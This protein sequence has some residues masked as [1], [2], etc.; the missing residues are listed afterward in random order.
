MPT[1]GG[2]IRGM[3]EKFNANPVTGTGSMTVP[4]ATSPGRSGFGPQLSLTYDSGRGNGPFGL[5]WSLSAPAIT[6]KTDKGLPR[7]DDANESDV[8]LLSDAEDLVPARDPTDGWARHRL[9]DPPHAP[10]YRIDR[11]RPRIERSFARVERWTRLSDG[12]AHWRVTTAE[13]VTTWYGEDEDSRIFDPDVPNDVPERV[14]SWLISRTYDDKGNVVVYRYVADD[15][16]GVDVSAAHERNRTD[17]VRGTNRY[18]KR[19]L[20][21]NRT[22]RLVEPDLDDPRWMF[23]VVLD[24]GD[25]DPESP[26]P[27]HDRDWPCREDPFSSYRSGFEVR[28]YRRCQRVLMFHHFPDEAGVGADCLVRSTVFEYTPGDAVGALLTQVHQRGHRR[29]DDGYVTRSLPPLELTYSSSAQHDE[30]REVD[31]ISLEGVPAGVGDGYQWVDLDGE[32]LSGILATDP[33]GW[34]YKRNVGGGRFA[35]PRLVTPLPSTAADSGTQPQ[36]LDLAG[37][38]QLDLVLLGAPTPG[39]FERTRTG[40]VEPPGWETFTAFRSR[41][42][43]DFD[44]PN[45]RFVDLDGD[46]HADVLITEDGA[47]RWYESL[48]EGGFDAARI[49]SVPVDEERGPRILFADATRSVHLADMSGDGLTDLVRIRNGEVCYWPN[50]GHG[51]FGPKVTMDGAPWFD[52]DETYD[53]RYLRLADV[54]G[55]GV[56]DL[57]YL[58]ADATRIWRN[59]SGNAW[60]EAQVLASAPVADARAQVAAVDLLGTGTTCLVWS[61]D[62]PTDARRNLRYIDLLGST[63]PHLLVRVANNLG[64]ETHVR[65]APSTRFYLEDRAA[66]RPWVTRLPFPVHVVERVET[67]DL[68]SRNRFVSRYAYH[69]GYFDGEERE[70][71]GFGM[72][73][74]WDT[75]AFTA[76]GGD[77]DFANEDP[78]SHVPPVHTKTWFHTGAFGAAGTSVSRYF[79]DEYW[80]EPGLT[81]DQQRA[82]LL[83]DT[84]WPTALLEPDGTRIDHVPTAEEIREACRALKGSM[85]RQEVYADDGSEAEERPHV[86]T[87]RNYRLDLLQPELDGDRHAVC[88]TSSLEAVTYQYE[89]TLYD[90]EHPDGS[91]ER[92]ADPR[93]SHDLTLDIDGYGNVLRAASV[94]YGR[95]H[96]DADLEPELPGWARDAI[97]DEQTRLRSTLTDNT[98]TNAIDAGHDHRTPRPCETRNYELVRLPAPG[99]STRTTTLFRLDA[100]RALVAAASD[101]DHDLPFEDVDA[102]G[103]T[104]PGVYRRLLSSTRTLYRRDD[105]SGA[106]P[107][108][109]LE[110]HALVDATYHLALPFS[111]IEDLYGPSLGRLGV[112]NEVD[113]SALLEGE[114][115]YVRI[116]SSLWRSSGRVFF[117]P[118]PGDS[119]SQELAYAER[120]FYLVH[121]YRDAFL[122]DSFVIYDSYELLPRGSR[123]ALGN[124]VTVGERAMDGAVRDGQDYRVLQPRMVTDA[125]GNR[126]AVVFDALGLV[127]GTAV[128]GKVGD[129]LGD[130]LEGFRI[131]LETD[132]VDNHLSD[133]VSTAASLLG[134][135]T[136][137][138]VYDHFA[139]WRTRHGAAQPPFTHSM[140]REDH[141]TPL[142]GTRIHHVLSFTDGLGRQ[143]QSKMRVGPGP[144]R[145]GTASV[146]HRW[147]TSGWTVYNNKGQ[148][149]RQ[150]EPFFTGLPDFEPDREHGVSPVLFYDALGRVVA[151]SHPDRTYRKQIHAPWRLITWDAADTVLLDLR[152]DPDVGGVGSAVFDALNGSS[153]PRSWYKQRID[154]S[155]GPEARDAAVKAARH[156]GTPA[157]L[158]FDPAG[159]EMCRVAHNRA[160]DETGAITDD[161]YPTLVRYDVEGRRLSII[162]ASG[163]VALVQRY[164]ASGSAISVRSAEGGPTIALVAADG[165]TARARDGRGHVTRTTYD[166]IRRPLRSYVR[167]VDELNERLVERTVYGEHHPD[168]EARNLRTRYHLHLDGAGLVASLANDFKGNPVETLRRVPTRRDEAGDWSRLDGLGDR[169]VAAA[170]LADLFDGEAVRTST[171]Y[172]ALDRPSDVRLRAEAAL[173][174]SP[175]IVSSMRY[176]YAAGNVLHAIKAQP[177]A[178][179]SAGSQPWHDV[180]TA[181]EYNARGQRS[182]VTY[183]NDATTRYVYDSATH[184]LVRMLTTRSRDAFPRDCPDENAGPCGLQNVE[185]TYDAY[186]NVTRITDAANQ[187]VFFGGAV[188]ES[189]MDLTYDPLYRLIE[190]RGREHAGQQADPEALRADAPGAPLPHPSDVQALRPYTERYSYDPVGNLQ[191]LVHLAPG[192]GWT[193][194]FQYAERSLI[195]HSQTSNRLSSTQVGSA[196]PETYEYDEHGNVRGLPG[197]PHLRWDHQDRLALLERGSGEAVFYTYDAN[198]QRVRKSVERT[199]GTL[200]SERLYVGVLEIY[201]EFDSAGSS[202]RL[203]RATLNVL[204]GPLRVAVIESRTQGVGTSPA[205]LVRYQLVNHL[206][207]VGLELDDQARVISYEEFHPYGTTAYHGAAGHLDAPKRYRYT[208]KE[209]DG[210]S[211][212]YYHG[213]RYYAPWLG[214]WTSPDPAGVVDGVN[215]YAYVRCNPVNF[216]DPTG[217]LSWGQWAGIA[218]AVVVGT[219]VTVATAGLAGP[220]VGATAAAVIGGIVGGAAGGAVGEV[221]E[222]AVDDRPITAANVGRAALIGAVA[223]GVFAGAAPIAGAV[224]RSSLG[225]AVASSAAAQLARSA[226]SRAA[227]S[228]VAQGARAIVQ[229]AANT[230]VGR[231]VGAGSRRVG[232]GLRTV[233]ESAE[234]AGA[235]VRERLESTAVKGVLPAERVPGIRP[236]QPAQVAEEFRTHFGERP[237]AIEVVGSR[238]EAQVTGAWP[239]GSGPLTSD[240]DMFIQTRVPNLSK[241]EGAGFEFFRDINP[242]RVPAGVTGIGPN[243]GQAYIGTSPGTIPKGGLIDPFFGPADALNGVSV[244]VWP[245]PIS[246]PL[247]GVGGAV[248]SGQSPD[249]PIIF[250]VIRAQW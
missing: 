164:D 80:H 226:V 7:Y 223:G 169:G 111:L 50:L 46:G 121:R 247:G 158:V 72:V 30:V 202:V 10:G 107:L 38:G 191:R 171:T 246:P 29:T 115:G 174:G 57:I 113:A 120:T 149:V 134:A 103:A 217:L 100:F 63:K 19:I 12:D 212:L 132:E 249:Q 232:E 188:A 18:L 35:P 126:S 141:V 236:G 82:L 185:Y 160:A 75:E 129:G 204:A 153:G 233:H 56:T 14:F 4:I 76:L 176:E 101:G 177:P 163:R 125:N 234:R 222:A 26:L 157:R 1:G 83:E 27:Q 220:V 155:L 37:D 16:R 25:H 150:Y 55:S 216:S 11:Y 43:V 70:F 168:A 230:S 229:R 143:L 88:L 203:E 235:R 118:D 3:G 5:G 237:E 208:G 207:S 184:R 214:R 146:S 211:G 196:S 99:S 215:A 86:V 197:S 133:P 199:D 109:A 81:V 239:E 224:A 44:D 186:G 84:V 6:R 97:R 28:T 52:R 240:V 90:I 162:D 110:P 178:L 165:K 42:Q 117:S 93:V 136:T 105:L 152:T 47:L 17:D 145:E 104:G 206:G 248:G 200:A 61:S 79:E 49:R 23:E 250:P 193:R 32:G 238:A 24:Y 147:V 98:F 209:R 131:D 245:T 154:G 244:P 156:A 227:A 66:G 179:A 34:S 243:P 161:L 77:V 170:P 68:I 102:V 73:E 189:G 241:H 85:L 182:V 33:A 22:S 173:P 40:D 137:R 221:V 78:A 59:R 60:A 192:G 65:Y 190:A 58:G 8:F 45:L 167:H 67:H 123:D 54:D 175:A 181:I 142:G 92:L 159:R 225:R 151:T 116:G 21:G 228:G 91:V 89:R 183:G 13:N 64:A 201:R 20:Y 166:E 187:R 39:F 36:L 119:P 9:V 95:R 242:G 219:V 128:M 138:I 205:R 135:A 130:S 15:A 180:V 194:R 106:L 96:P 210:E 195:D 172:D 112:P 231:A 139:F 71:R 41:P 108:G 69:H 31:P 51:Q 144:L 74:Q 213:A 2:A 48:G 140:T 87:E 62:H 122:Q 148:P 114:C 218:A 127:V 198:G 124:I 53:P 94:A